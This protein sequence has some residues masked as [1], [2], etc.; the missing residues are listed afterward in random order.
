MST[1][2]NVSGS[3]G[4]ASSDP[5]VVDHRHRTR[6]SE[7]AGGPPMPRKLIVM[8]GGGSAAVLDQAVAANQE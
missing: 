1:T 3:A 7:M 2:P 6:D 4:E 5:T 8:I